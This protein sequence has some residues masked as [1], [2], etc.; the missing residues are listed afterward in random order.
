MVWVVIMKILYFAWVRTRIGLS[1]ETVTAPSWVTD[2]TG[3][4]AWLCTRTSGHAAAFSDL[5]VVR[6]AVNQVYVD[7]NHQIVPRDEVAFFPPVTG[8]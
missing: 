7:F 6:A 5:S 8:G 2:I 4:L 3:L 1:E